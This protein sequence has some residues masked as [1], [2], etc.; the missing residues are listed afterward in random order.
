MMLAFWPVR[1]VYASNYLEVVQSIGLLLLGSTSNIASGTDGSFEFCLVVARRE[2]SI[3]SI[4]E[5]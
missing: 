5:R 4:A 1:V 2:K 3:L